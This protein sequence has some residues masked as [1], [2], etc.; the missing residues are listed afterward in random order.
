MSYYTHARDE[1]TDFDEYNLLPYSGGYDIYLTFSRPLDSS[2][3]T[4]YP[5][6]S[7]SDDF[8]Y[9]GHPEGEYEGRLQPAYVFQPS[10]EERPEFGSDRPESGYGGKPEY[11]YSGSEYESGYQRRPEANEPNSEYIGYGRKPGHEAP[12]SDLPPGCT[13]PASSSS[14]PVAFL[15]AFRSASKPQQF[16]HDNEDSDS[17]YVKIKH[18]L[19]DDDADEVL[20]ARLINCGP[21]FVVEDEDSDGDWAN[22]E[23]TSEEKEEEVEG[24]EDVDVVGKALRKC[25]KIS[26]YLRNELHGNSTPAVSDRYTEVEVVIV[27]IVNQDDIIEACRSE[28]SDFQPIL[29]PY[30]LVG[31]NFLFLLYQEGIGGG[32]YFFCSL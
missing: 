16:S 3:E 7:L 32:T 11:G 29:K 19:E 1:A 25:A 5:N 12:E 9:E 18:E 27:R 26:M 31:V 13:Q 21:R 4:C 15:F 14:S 23:S 30:Q 20:E 8:D 2:D 6:S 22:I 17:D 10:G 24:L 28:D